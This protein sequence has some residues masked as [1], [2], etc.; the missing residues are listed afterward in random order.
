MN[1][2][3]KGTDGTDCKCFGPW[4]TQAFNTYLTWHMI[5]SLV[6]KFP[7]AKEGTT[8]QLRGSTTT[9][10]IRDDNDTSLW[11]NRD[12]R[13]R[14]IAHLAMCCLIQMQNKLVLT[15]DVQHASLMISM[16]SWVRS[17][18]QRRSLEASAEITRWK[19]TKALSPGAGRMMM[20]N[21][22]SLGSQTPTMF[23]RG[24]V[25]FSVLNTGRALNR[26]KHMH[27][28]DGIPQHMLID[29]C[30]IMEKVSWQYR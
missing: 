3:P 11:M 10:H 13:R 25:G 22:E 4:Y 1:M 7:R 20:L 29:V 17:L 12:Q 18:R 6:W 24:E 30:C 28:D 26:R 8:S 2:F 19:S 9:L 14:K 21:K 5:G 15:T 23:Q 16:T 27:K